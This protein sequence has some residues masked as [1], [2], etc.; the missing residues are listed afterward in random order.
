MKGAKETT[1]C[2]PQSLAPASGPEHKPYL[3]AD[4][5]GLGLEDS[6]GTACPR[7]ES[8]PSEYC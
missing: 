2:I 8:F 4:E 3:L 5:L 6:L 1:C 7:G